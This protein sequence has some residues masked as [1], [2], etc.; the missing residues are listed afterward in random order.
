MFLVFYIILVRVS[1]ILFE[2]K[3]K[4]KKF[5]LQKLTTLCDYDVIDI[6]VV[7]GFF[8]SCN[9][10]FVAYDYDKLIDAHI[11]QP[12]NVLLEMRLIVTR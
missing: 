5:G 6:D 8:L 7:I 10:S 11:E 3:Q 12:H 2:A 9:H 1:L 4:L